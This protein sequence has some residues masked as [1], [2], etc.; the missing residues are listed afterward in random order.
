[1]DAWW[2]NIL[3][4]NRNTGWARAYHASTQFMRNIG[5]FSVPIISDFLELEFGLRIGNKR[6]GF[7]L[8]Q[9]LTLEEIRFSM[10]RNYYSKYIISY[11]WK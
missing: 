10:K 5:I 1:M 6:L 8:G 3:A 9:A 7:V 4:V 11:S 2:C